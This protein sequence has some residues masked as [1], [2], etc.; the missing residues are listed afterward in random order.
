MRQGW[1]AM[2][3]VWRRPDQLG[4]KAFDAAP[5]LDL[6]ATRAQECQTQLQRLARRRVD[7]AHAAVSGPTSRHLSCLHLLLFRS[8]APATMTS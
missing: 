4:G 3:L 8:G 2:Q 6:P 7:C 1:G 5:A